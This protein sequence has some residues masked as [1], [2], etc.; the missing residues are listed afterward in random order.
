MPRSDP[1]LCF[2]LVHVH[3]QIDLYH[4]CYNAFTCVGADPD[5]YSPVRVQTLIFIPL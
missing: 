4:C 2:V 5:L 3:V 1:D